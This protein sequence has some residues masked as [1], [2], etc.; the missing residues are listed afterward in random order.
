MV[1]PWILVVVGLWVGYMLAGQAQRAVERLDKVEL[2][3]GG[4]LSQIEDLIP[5]D[6]NGLP[7]GSEAPA[8][9]LP[10]LVGRP[11]LF[12]EEY[13]GRRVLLTFLSSTCPHSIALAPEFAK[14]TWRGE[15]GRPSPV[16]VAIGDAEGNRAMIAEH[17]IRCPVLLDEQFEILGAYEAGGT[18]AAYLIDEDGVIAAPR[19]DGGPDVLRL[20]ERPFT[21]RAEPRHEPHEPES[22]AHGQGAGH[23][24]GVG[25]QHGVPSAAEGASERRAFRLPFSRVPEEGVGV[26]DLVKRMTDVLGIKPCRGCEGRRQSWNRWVIKGSGG[27]R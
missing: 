17:D 19:A 16:V 26:G 20:A 21:P 3:C 12:N 7:A 15:A 6:V 10:D 18:P 11:V 25:H 4:L 27:R 22:G 5:D 24:H 9:E 1:L 2:N 23:S 8:F 14:L 13:R